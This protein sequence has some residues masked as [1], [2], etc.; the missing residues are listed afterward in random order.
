MREY[1]EQVCTHGFAVDDS[2]RGIEI[3]CLTV[4]IREAARRVIITMSCA[5]TAAQMAR[6]SITT[7][8]TSLQAIATA[9]LKRVGYRGA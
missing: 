3:P 1:L 4:L 8:F 5:G 6:I 9:L 7:L 2:E